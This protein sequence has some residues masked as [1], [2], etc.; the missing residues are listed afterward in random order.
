MAA[1][2]ST[3][4]TTRTR[5]KGVAVIHLRSHVAPGRAG[6]ALALLA[7]LPLALL[8][9]LE[10]FSSTAPQPLWVAQSSGILKVQQADGAVALEIPSAADVQAL[11]VDGQRKRVWAYAGKQLRSY[12]WDGQ[13]LSVTN[14]DPPAGNPTLLLVDSRADRVWLAVQTQVQLFDG[15][16]R[17]LWQ[18]RLPNP[19][20]GMAVDSRRSHLWVGHKGTLQVHDASGQRLAQL[21]TPDI[22]QVRA[23]DYDARLDQV[24]VAADDTV[25]RFAPNG[26]Q[27]F[28][29][30]LNWLARVTAIAADQDGGLWLTDSRQLAYLDAAG[31]VAFS[32]TPALD[33]LGPFVVSLVADARSH[34]A[35][36]ASQ[37]RVAHYA[38]GGALIGEFALDAGDPSRRIR[39]LALPAGP[40]AP[41][42][43]FTAPPSGSVLGTSRPT[44]ALNYSGDGV[45]PATLTLTVDAAPLPV[46]C[47]TGA[48]AATCT[49]I[50]ALAEGTHDIAATIADTAG[51]VSDAALVRIEIDTVAPVVTVT[52]PADGALTNV[53]SVRIDGALSEPAALTVNGVAVTVASDRRFSH[54]AALAEGRNDF[55]LRA[56]DAAG[57]VGTRVLHVVLDTVPPPAPV[58]G[59]IQ[60]DAAGGL[61]TV[62]GGAGAVEGGSRVTLVNTRTGERVTVIAN[63]DGSF[64]ATLAGEAGDVVQIHA[65]DGAGNQGAAGSLE[66]V[67]GPFS[68]AITLGASSPASGATVDGDRILVSVDVSA[69]PNTGVTVNDVVAVGVPGPSGLRFYAEVP[70]ETGSN[71]LAVK[72]HG[73]DGRVVTRTI[74]VTSRGPFP[75]RV[76]ADRVAGVAPL[77]AR[78]EVWD[79]SGRGI[80]QVQV[81][82]DGDGTMDVI[83]EPGDPIELSYTGVGLRQ[84]R[85]VVFDNALQ[86]HEQRVSFVLLDLA[87]VDRSIQ[88]VWGA[89]KEA[90]A[91]GDKDGAMSYLSEQARENYGPVFDALMPRMPEIVASFSEPRRSLVMADYA[92]YGVNQTAGGGNSIYLTG[93]VTNQFGQWQL[94]TM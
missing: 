71:T 24:W 10:A 33:A 22:R 27:V 56:V 65:T 45:D 75:Y 51:N 84:A 15:Q 81:D 43:E 74:S 73:Q 47:V 36:I 34:S 41:Q 9:G 83:A 80:R 25:R 58:T 87:T 23:L 26:A 72:A 69:P 57:N 70:L 2:K 68:G 1:S 3:R 11:A 13:S 59:R 82:A 91:S 88:A 31:A 52:A 79:Q 35:W 19:V 30:A 44:F 55:A 29:L 38:P 76:V 42:I 49:A 20:A 94:D 66:A 32:V 53:A 12:G 77:A 50:Q 86:P 48:E 85:V 40:I 60:A 93:Y 39:Q 78:L 64:S 17:S 18:T 46:S 4:C 67:G 62:S 54:V 6:V 21:A 63:A 92:E 28:S 37:R 8:F 89:M 5:T 14:V 90:L 7:A 16:G 61:I